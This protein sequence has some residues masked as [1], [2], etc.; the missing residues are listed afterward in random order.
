VACT[1]A[2]TYH[3]GSSER[4][5][6]LMFGFEGT[7]FIGIVFGT[8]TL[9]GNRSVLIRGQRQSNRGEKIILTAVSPSAPSDE[10]TLRECH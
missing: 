2:K 10:R 7:I 9:G 8:P 6:R 1:R 3:G 4:N 5:P